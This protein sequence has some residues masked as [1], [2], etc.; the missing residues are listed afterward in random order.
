MLR[1]VGM[2]NDQYMDNLIAASLSAHW[3]SEGGFKGRMT[4]FDA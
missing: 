3:G 1:G 2:Y 4:V